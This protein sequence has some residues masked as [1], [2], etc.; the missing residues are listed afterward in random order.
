MM[1]QPNPQIAVSRGRGAGGGAHRPP[2]RLVARLRK[3]LMA[4]QQLEARLPTPHACDMSRNVCCTSVFLFQGRAVVG[5]IQDLIQS[6]EHTHPGDCASS[7]PRAPVV[8]LAAGRDSMD[9]HGCLRSEIFK[10]QRQRRRTP[11]RPKCKV[12]QHRGNSADS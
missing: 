11:T 8:K 6:S 7:A 2:P 5:E 4:T 10:F 12:S 9:L 1:S 3:A